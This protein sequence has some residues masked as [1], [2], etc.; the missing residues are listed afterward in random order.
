MNNSEFNKILKRMKGKGI[1]RRQLNTR[2]PVVRFGPRTKAETKRLA[3][4]EASRAARSNDWLL[5]H[6][7]VSSEVRV[8]TNVTD[9]DWR[10]SDISR[11]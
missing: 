9:D 3:E 1:A 4:Q 2:Q 6:L 5:S 7:I 8:T 11:C 10:R